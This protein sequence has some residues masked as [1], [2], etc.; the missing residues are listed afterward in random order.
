MADRTSVKVAPEIR[1]R[2]RAEKIGGET[3]DDVLDR[4]LNEQHEQRQGVEA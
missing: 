1:D 2:L 3:Y 4:L